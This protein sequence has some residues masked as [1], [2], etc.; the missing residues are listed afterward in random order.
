MLSVAYLYRFMLPLSS[1]NVLAAARRAATASI[2]GHW[3][4]QRLSTCSLN[5]RSSRGTREGGLSSLTTCGISNWTRFPSLA[6]AT[7]FTAIMPHQV[8]GFSDSHKHTPPDNSVVNTYGLYG[9]VQELQREMQWF[10]VNTDKL[11]EL[12]ASGD[13]QLF[14]VREPE[15]LVQTGQ[16]PGAVNLPRMYI[17]IPQLI[18]KLC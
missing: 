9:S 12:L 5:S 13:I 18:D 14:D 4:G 8:R 16:I 7:P 10:N 15:E 1:Y 6:T 11:V 3:K 17:I 2:A